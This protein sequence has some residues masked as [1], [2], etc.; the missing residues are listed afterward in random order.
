M[1][2]PIVIHH[3]MPHLMRE[4]TSGAWAVGQSLA[5]EHMHGYDTLR[6]D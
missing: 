5:G 6:V 2:L 4:Y 1:G 3:T